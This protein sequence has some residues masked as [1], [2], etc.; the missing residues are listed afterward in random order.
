M[1]QGHKVE[2]PITPWP[3]HFL[4]PWWSLPYRERRQKSNCLNCGCLNLSIK[5][6]EVFQEFTLESQLLCGYFTVS[7]FFHA[8]QH[9]LFVSNILKK[10][11]L[12]KTFYEAVDML[13]SLMCNMIFLF[14]WQL[15]RDRFKCLGGTPIHPHVQHSP[16]ASSPF[17]VPRKKNMSLW[18]LTPPWSTS[19]LHQEAKHMPE[20]LTP[21]LP[22]I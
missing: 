11:H 16:M 3:L 6:S 21:A 22:S 18:T 1:G 14:C 13:S 20:Q 7:Q 2:G 17:P 8:H 19:T 9:R 12:L 15:Y 10:C 4:C 5:V